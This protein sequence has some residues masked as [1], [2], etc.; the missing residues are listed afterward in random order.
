M[1]KFTYVKSSTVN[2]TKACILELGKT[3]SILSQLCMLM[4]L[5]YALH[6]PSASEHVK[7]RKAV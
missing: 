4:V 6:T 1:Q 5:Y 7:E 3:R 2:D